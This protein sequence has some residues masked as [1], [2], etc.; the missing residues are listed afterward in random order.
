MYS[1]INITR[2]LSFL[3]HERF[4]STAFCF[5]F[6]FFFFSIFFFF[7]IFNYRCFEFLK[8]LSVRQTD[9]LGKKK[10]TTTKKNHHRILSFTA[11]LMLML[12]CLWMT[13]A[14]NTFVK[15]CSPVGSN[16]FKNLFTA[17]FWESIILSSWAST[18]CR[19][20]YCFN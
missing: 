18:F 8:F 17:Q 19:F 7:F 6:S 10:A 15:I 4:T 12:G 14:N 2:S 11:L 5:L 13:E 1:C 9:T 20:V 3:F 16:D